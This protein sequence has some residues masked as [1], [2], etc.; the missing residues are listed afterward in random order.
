MGR[1]RHA[2]HT[3]FNGIKWLADN[4]CREAVAGAGGKGDEVLH[5]LVVMLDCLLIVDQE[6]GFW[7]GRT[8]VVLRGGMVC[9]E[10]R[11]RSL[12]HCKQ[13]GSLIGK[14]SLLTVILI[15][16]GHI[17]WHDV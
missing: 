5:N 1:R 9:M 16:L 15:I 14:G 12:E 2:L 17:L 13:Y 7:C 8:L 10:K 11:A 6:K 4:D 3:N